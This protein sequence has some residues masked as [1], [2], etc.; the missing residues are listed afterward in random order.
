MKLLL[1]G[2]IILSMYGHTQCIGEMTFL[3][4]CQG[5]K[6]ITQGDDSKLPLQNFS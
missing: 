2:I 1:M 4:Q 5:V 3:A 6:D